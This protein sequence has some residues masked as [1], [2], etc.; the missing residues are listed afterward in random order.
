MIL[1]GLFAP[2]AECSA[3]AAL[4]MAYFFV[5]KSQNSFDVRWCRGNVGDLIFD[6]WVRE[7]RS[8]N[9]VFETCTRVTGFETR[10]S[11]DDT[12]SRVKC[13]TTTTDGGGGGK[14]WTLE[15]DTVV[16]AVGGSALNA[17]VRNSPELAKHADF[18][19]FANL[20]GVSVLATRLYLDRSVEPPFSANAC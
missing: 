6:P 1:T 15:A 10:A 16:F 8:R 5:L 18:H 19:Q 3:A 17:M 13:T 12:I 9:V 20:R 14:E 11:N 7:M 4:G 2:G